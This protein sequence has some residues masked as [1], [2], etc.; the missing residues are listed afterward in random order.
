[1]SSEQRHLLREGRSIG[2][3]LKGT[4][5]Q[6]RIIAIMA[7]GL[8]VLHHLLSHGNDDIVVKSTYG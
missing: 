5:V 3:A 8:P 2:G 6:F 4:I 1:L 7:I